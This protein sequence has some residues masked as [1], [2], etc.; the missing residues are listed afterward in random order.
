MAATPLRAAAETGYP[1]FSTVDTQGR[2]DGFAVELLRSTLQA[3]GREVRFETG[4]WNEVKS[5][6]V[7]RKVQVLPLVGRTPEREAQFDFTFPYMTMHG[8]IIVRAGNDDEIRS[9]GD[10]EGRQVA[11]MA[12]DNAEEFLR[13]SGGSVSIATTASSLQALEELAAGKHDAVVMQKLL[14]VQLMHQHD[15]DRLRIAG[16]PLEEF[17]QSFC[18][19]VA[20]GDAELL[21]LLNEGL[22]LV[23]ADGTFAHL[24][25]TWFGQLENPPRS[26]I[27]IGGDFNYP[28]YEYLDKNGQPAGYNVELTRALAERLGISVDIQLGPWQQV[29]EKLADGRLDLVQGM[30]YSAERDA[31]FDF[32]DAHSRISHV[33]VTRKELPDVTNLDELAGHVIVVMKGD[34][35]HDLLLDAGYEKQLLLAETQEEAVELV[36]NTYADYALLAKVPAL[37]WIRERQLDN[38]RVGKQALLSAEYCYA[39]AHDQR[40]LVERFSSALTDLKAEGTYRKIHQKWLGPYRDEGISRAQLM[41]YALYSAL[42]PVLLLLLAVSWSRTLRRKVQAQTAHLEEEIEQRVRVEERLRDSEQ[43]YRLLAD[44][45]HDW[46]Y[47]LDETGNYRYVSPSCEQITGYRAEEFIAAPEL[48]FE[49]VREDH[50]ETVRHHFH[51][52]NSAEFSSCHLSFPILARSGE[53]RW[54]DHYCTA[55]FDDQG[56]FVG[57]RGNNRDITE[58]VET[59]AA[60]NESHKSYQRIFD[61][62]PIGIVTVTPDGKL[63]SVNPFFCRFLGY[64]AAELLGLSVQDISHPD[65]YSGEVDRI[66]QIKDNQETTLQFEKRY[67]HKEGHY[68]WGQLTTRAVHSE[69]GALHIGLGLVEDLTESKRFA[70]ERAKLEEQLRQKYKMEAVGVMAGGIAHN[71]NNNLGIILGNLELAEIREREGKSLTDMLRNAK[72]AV[73]R[74]R[75]LVQQIL[76]YSR[77][78]GQKKG[79][80]HAA[81]V[82]DET[83]KLL[84]STLPATIRL[85]EHLAA[86]A[87]ELCIEGD[88]GQL[89]EALL[90]LCTNAIHAMDEEGELHI[91]LERT[92][93]DQI[94]IPAQYSSSPGPYIRIAVSDTGCGMDDDTMARIFDPFFTT[95][96]VDQ[97]TGMGLAS[98]QGIVEQ[99]GGVIRVDS[100]PGLGSR[101]ALYFPL[102]QAETTEEISQEIV[103]P[104]QGR[105]KILLVDDEPMLVEL[106][107][108][109]L[110]ELGYQVSP[111][112]DSRQ[113]LDLFVANQ[114]FFDLVITDQTMPGLTGRELIAQVKQLRPELPTILCTGYSSKISEAEAQEYKIDGYCL[115]PLDLHELARAVRRVL[116]RNHEQ[117]VEN[118]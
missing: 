14:A 60:L 28:P 43:K 15:L 54:L 29:R 67:R 91:S 50:R 78:G 63:T 101:F 117:L 110:E 59:A 79:S 4:P 58:R 107:Q 57:R 76:T 109:M 106:G 72:T 89:Q 32:T 88:A 98:V 95:K 23:M 70:A 90:N 52:E 41:R 66:R 73:L 83:L 48:L 62:A 44:Y 25:R 37:Y 74:S 5:L 33:S 111:L 30:F 118:A 80:L 104:P 35:M 16:P 49:I 26:R 65:E 96:D 2:A 113:A 51:Q 86:D 55:V 18:F 81:L 24:R 47:W 56:R 42:P 87:A 39:G 53:E 102:S 22:S 82:L 61:N 75:D 20:E 100:A 103:E 1:P 31:Q 21:S 115:K 13:R 17:E 10:L 34:I 40:E 11:V 7:N 77:Q 85:N 71:F 8:A 45:T 112:T 6:L 12:G 84:R 46:E 19:A 38:L 93:L 105:E 36:A 68:V 69:D 116:D 9:L 3:M 108:S 64:S 114:H 99:H 97:G 27:L 92:V 94:E